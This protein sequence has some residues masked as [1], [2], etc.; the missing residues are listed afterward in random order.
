MS[1]ENIKIVQ[2]ILKKQNKY[3]IAIKLENGYYKHERIDY[4]NS[5]VGVIN[6]FVNPNYFLELI[7]IDE[8]NSKMLVDIFDGLV[9]EYSI[10]HIK[11]SIDTNIEIENFDDVVYI[12]VDE[13][14]NMD[15]TSSGSKYFMFNFLIKKRP[16]SL[17]VPISNYRYTLLEKNLNPLKGNDR[18]LNIESFHACKDNKYI[19]EEIFNIISTFDENIVKAYSYILEKPKVNPTTR[20]KDYKFYIDNLTFAI[21]K[22]LDILAIDKSFLII[23]DNL[24]IKKNEKYQVK[25]LKE[26]VSEYIQENNLNIRYDIFHHCSA[27]SVNLQIVDYISWAIYRKYEHGQDEFYEKI[28]KYLI[29]I[30]D[31]TKARKTN[32]Y[33][34]MTHQPIFQEKKSP[35]ATC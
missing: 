25:A 14:G 10:S 33:E 13:S 15:F 11:F 4:Y 26:G 34:I 1:K 18:R 23:T 16:F 21:K 9:H 5:L 17:H 12:F 8:E 2:N 27:S 6:I 28:K 3:D 32:H 19:K 24:P 22:L 31:M 30:D 29:K 35:L 7:N 20:E